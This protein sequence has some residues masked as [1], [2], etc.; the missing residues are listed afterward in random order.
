MDISATN[1]GK[2][3]PQKMLSFKIINLLCTSKISFACVLETK[4]FFMLALQILSSF[5]SFLISNL[6]TDSICD[7]EIPAHI[8][9]PF[10]QQKT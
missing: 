2:F 8:S 4:L 9:S 3:L 6:K 7:V 10:T 1:N 5:K